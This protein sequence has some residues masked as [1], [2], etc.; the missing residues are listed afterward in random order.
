MYKIA[1]I[2]IIIT[3]ILHASNPK[4]YAALGDVIYNNAE[5]IQSLKN[6]EKYADQKQDIDKYIR[7]VEA[8]KKLGFK[9]ESGQIKESNKEYLNSLRKLS[10]TNDYYMRSIQATYN[11]AMKNRDFDLFYRMI[12]GKFIDVRK[13]KKEILDYYF[14]N[15]ES[16]NTSGV[17]EMFLAEDATLKAKKKKK[18]KQYKTK[19]ELEEEKIQRIRKNDTEEKK[20]IERELEK[21][22][23]LRKQKIREEQ[24]RELT[25]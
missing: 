22:L 20:R 11:S 7:E 1:F 12:N 19:K 13:H 6:I 23:E 2:A 17:I 8:A 10:K 3:T 21:E 14:K 9:I 18:R 15:K 24:K 16:I 5:I 25:D 4:P